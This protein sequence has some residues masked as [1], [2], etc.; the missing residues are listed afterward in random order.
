MKPA[1]PI[2]FWGADRLGNFYPSPIEIG[3]RT[4]GTVEHYY[5]AQKFADDPKLYDEIASAP[6]PKTAKRIAI[7]HAAEAR[8]DWN[9]VKERVMH[10]ACTAKFRQHADLREYLLSTEY[11]EL[12]EDSPTD[13]YWGIA[14]GKGKNRLG[15]ILMRIRTELRK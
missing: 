2:L 13:A 4:Y 15:E 7:A 8:A 5:Q 9:D 6:D 1:E 3:G 12:I 11:R 10:E 14:D